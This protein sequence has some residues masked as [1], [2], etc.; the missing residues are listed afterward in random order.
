MGLAGMFVKNQFIRIYR[1]LVFPFR[2][3]SLMIGRRVMFG[4]GG[5]AD[6]ATYFEGN[7]YVG[8]DT[9]LSEC[10]LGRGSYVGDGS[11]ICKMVTGKY[12]SVGFNVTTAIGTHPVRENIATSPSLFSV[13][14]ANN[15]S[16][17]SEQLFE[18][19]NGI[20]TLGNDVWIGNSAILM[21]G[22]TIGDG[23]IVGAGSVVTKSVE[24]YSIN[25]GVP[26]KCIGKRFDDDVITSLEEL[27]WWNKDDKWLVE[28]AKDFACPEDFIA[29][30]CK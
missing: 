15:L 19:S 6:R 3:L 30:V 18:D 28:H 26:A 12:C 4:I 20:V 17:T 25:V 29:K 13:N 16:F 24:P 11:R 8:Q 5:Y 21:A 1:V 23:A 22:V 9:F 10:F 14:P 27:K 2:K 7:N